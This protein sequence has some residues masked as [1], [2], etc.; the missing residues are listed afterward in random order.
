[1][2]R[3]AACVAKVGIE[4]SVQPRLRH[5]DDIDLE[6]RNADTSRGNLQRSSIEVQRRT[7]VDAEVLQCQL[8]FGIPGGGVGNRIDRSD[9]VE[10]SGRGAGRIE[11]KRA[12]LSKYSCQYREL[13]RL[14][15]Q[16]NPSEPLPLAGQ[17]QTGIALELTCVGRSGR[18]PASQQRSTEVGERDYSVFIIDAGVETECRRLDA[19]PR[20][21]QRPDNPV[22]R[23]IPERIDRDRHGELEGDIAVEVD[24]CGDP[25]PAQPPRQGTDID[26]AKRPIR[27]PVPQLTLLLLQGAHQH[28]RFGRCR[29]RRIRQLGCSRCLRFR[30]RVAGLCPAVLGRSPKACQCEPHAS[31]HPTPAE[32]SSSRDLAGS[33][34]QIKA[35][36]RLAARFVTARSMQSHHH[37]V[38]PIVAR[39]PMQASQEVRSGSVDA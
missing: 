4:I 11:G 6:L 16:V 13:H 30:L 36:Q 5:V 31:D 29:V 25:D 39:Q 33:E 19:K 35:R 34:R 38:Y 14:H 21:L 32:P 8:T 9:P 10:R 28:D 27:G 26:V 2:C 3:P 18:R 20:T 15:L 12:A 23:C 24:R 37:V 7:V 22:S 17:P 1:M